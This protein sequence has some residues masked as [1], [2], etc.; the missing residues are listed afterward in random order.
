[1][2][3]KSEKINWKEMLTKQTAPLILLLMLILFSFTI[4]KFFSI[5]N[6]TNILDSFAVYGV[7]TMAM[8]FSLIGGE[9]DLSVGS[10]MAFSSLIFA[11]NVNERGLFIG[12]VLA[13]LSGLVVGALN[14]VLVA[15]FGMASFVATMSTQII[16][17]GAALW[18]T[19]AQAVAIYSEACY[20]IGN[21]KFLGISYLFW[22]FLLVTFIFAF[23]LK[24]TAFGRGLYAVGGNA[25]IAANAGINVKLYKFIIFVILG[26]ASAIG[27]IM[28]ACRISA[29]NSLYGADLT[30]MAISASVV[31]G[32]SNTGGTGSA[33]RTFCGLCVLYVLY[34][35]LMLLGIQAYVQQLLKGL[36]VVFV[37]I[38]AGISR[39]SKDY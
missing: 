9:F 14:G 8:C 37:I 7:V 11:V 39:V 1:M 28:M 26:V 17:K 36:I 25:L 33:A 24:Y 30:M 13:L 2:K 38:V 21:G 19:D 27:G 34:N 6:L 10:I 5:G 23:V 20:Q 12:L 29:G 31:G 4:P 15:K 22:F 35:A 16:V 32:T 18:Y 3:S